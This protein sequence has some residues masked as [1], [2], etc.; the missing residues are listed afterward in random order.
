MV[1]L[2][3]RG[4]LTLPF[5]LYSFICL[6]VYVS[7]YPFLTV[8][9][10]LLVHSDTCLGRL[11]VYPFTPHCLEHIFWCLFPNN[12]PKFLPVANLLNTFDGSTLKDILFVVDESILTKNKKSK[13][14]TKKL[15]TAESNVGIPIQIVGRYVPTPPLPT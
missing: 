9:S 1:S 3:L 7:F 2:R 14:D 13:D 11:F 12:L 15:R 4:S 10:C 8:F 6:C 5:Y